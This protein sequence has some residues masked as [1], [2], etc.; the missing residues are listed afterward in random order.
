MPELRLPNYHWSLDLPALR[1]DDVLLNGPFRLFP[2]TLGYELS[3]EDIWCGR[4]DLN[5][6]ATFKVASR[7]VSVLLNAALAG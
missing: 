4:R 1:F 6:R 3:L 2:G 5:S 7:V